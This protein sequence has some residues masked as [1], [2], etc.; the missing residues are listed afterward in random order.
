MTEAF[1][2]DAG[3]F[4]ALVSVVLF[5]PALFGMATA[6]D[7]VV[8]DGEGAIDAVRRFG[9]CVIEGV[10]ERRGVDESR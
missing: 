4:F 1:A 9:A 3:V 10:V 2:L 6:S 8:F 5:D 7:E